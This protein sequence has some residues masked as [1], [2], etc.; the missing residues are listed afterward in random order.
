MDVSIIIVNY[1]TVQLLIDAVD[2][3]FAKTE[4]IEYEIIVVDNNSNDNSKVILAERYGGKITY[5]GLSENIGF[6]R[7]NNEAAKIAKGRNIFFLNPD[8]ILL[9]NAVKILSDYLDDNPRVGCCGG[10]LVNVIGNP[11]LSY[12]R[13]QY[14]SLFFEI[15]QLFLGLPAKIVYGKNAIYNH[16]N[17]TLNVVEITGA[18]LMIRKDLFDRLKG[19]APD[20]FMYSEEAELEYRVRK[21]GYKIVSVPYARI[22]HFVGQSSQNHIDKIKKTYASRI[23]FLQKTHSPIAIMIT[24]ALSIF[25]IK[26]RL[27]VFTFLRNKEKIVLWSQHYMLKHGV[28]K[29]NKNMG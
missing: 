17:K 25:N 12:V 3:V 27:F 2:S 28:E 4:G 19:F 22:I 5:L 10:N 14:W 23:I 21:A 15:N 16:T 13:I 18:D 8:T 9:N 1:N 7:A 29:K 26:L 24:N 11:I 6:G 20:F